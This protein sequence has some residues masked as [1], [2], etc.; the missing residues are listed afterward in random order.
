M[1]P[2]DAA[3][4]SFLQAAGSA[5]AMTV[6]LGAAGQLF[7]IGRRL[8]A[9]GAAIL[10]PISD[11]RAVQVSPSEVFTAAEAAEIFEHYTQTD[12]VGE[13]F[14]LR[15]IDLSRAQSVPR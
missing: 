14:A 1:V 6:E 2:E 11:A 3:G 9:P 4:D 12:G 5:N 13:Q 7:T 8:A 10:I 15:A